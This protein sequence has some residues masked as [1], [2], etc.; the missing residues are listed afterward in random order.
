MTR[1][2]RF[3]KAKHTDISDGQRGA[4]HT[5]CRSLIALQQP[6]FSFASSQRSEPCSQV[7]PRL[8]A[9]DR[10]FASVRF[11]SGDARSWA[12]RSQ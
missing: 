10:S 4:Q 2:R 6:P 12:L 3:V 5:E 9:V 8:T 1:T 11:C 7:N